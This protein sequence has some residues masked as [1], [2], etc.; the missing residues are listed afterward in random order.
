M[1]SGKFNTNDNAEL[2]QKTN[3]DFSTTNHLLKDRYAA[4][5]LS[6]LQASNNVSEYDGLTKIRFW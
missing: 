1:V 3:F 4:P 6:L 2:I 5:K